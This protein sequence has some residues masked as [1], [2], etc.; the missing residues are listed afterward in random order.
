MCEERQVVALK[1]SRFARRLKEGGPSS[2]L[3]SGRQVIPFWRSAGAAAE[4]HRIER[5]TGEHSREHRVVARVEEDCDAEDVAAQVRWTT[6]AF[7]SAP[8]SIGATSNARGW[9]VGAW[10]RDQPELPTLELLRRAKEHGLRREQDRVLRV[11]GVRSPRAAPIVRFEGLPG[12]F[13][14]HDFGHVDVRLVDGCKQRVHFF[15]SRLKYPRFVA[16]TR[17]TFE[18]RAPS[19]PTRGTD[20]ELSSA[21]RRSGPSPDPASSALQTSDALHRGTP[22][23]EYHLEYHFGVTD[24]PSG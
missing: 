1:Q 3:R 9:K 13:S 23:S 21:R 24:G 14:Q 15:A 7:A 12:E 19:M 4:L 6:K 22:L 2:A 17:I 20:G 8:R 18:L 11:A 5:G 10:L 16:V